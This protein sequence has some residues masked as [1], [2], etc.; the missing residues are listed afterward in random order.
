M[1]Q[2]EDEKR[3]SFQNHSWKS[4]DEKFKI[5]FFSIPKLGIARLRLQFLP[6]QGP[7]HEAFRFHKAAARGWIGPTARLCHIT[8]QHRVYTYTYVY[9]YVSIY[10]S[11]YPS[12]HPS[13]YLS[14]YL[15]I[16]LSVYLSICLSIYLS[17]YLSHID[18]TWHSI[19]CIQHQIS[20]PRHLDGGAKDRVEDRDLALGVDVE[21]FP[22]EVRRGPGR[23][24][25][26]H[27]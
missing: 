3:H 8:K 6:G 14:V 25:R 13:I 17:I 18:Y 27:D 19:S 26:G 9:I 10:L 20:H 4:T 11:I 1:K 2:V 23:G 15:S 5:R 7:F 16:C 22:L 21:I 24:P 12:I